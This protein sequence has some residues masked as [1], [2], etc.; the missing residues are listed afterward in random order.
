MLSSCPIFGRA[1][2]VELAGEPERAVAQ[3]PRAGQIGSA[4]DRRQ[5]G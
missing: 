1:F 4:A 2:A 3:D 5:L